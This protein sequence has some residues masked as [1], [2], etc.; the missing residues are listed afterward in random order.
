[1][2]TNQ[3]ESVTLEVLIELMETL[4][5]E[6]GC[7]WD[8]KQTKDSLK[9]Y[10]IEESY[11]VVEAVDERDPLKIKEELG[12]LLF[13]IVFYSQLLQKEDGIDIYD[14]IEA[15]HRKMV[16][17]HPHVF[18][19]VTVNGADEVVVNWEQIKQEEKKAERSSVLDGVPKELPS[20]LRAHR[21]QSKASS[22]GFEWENFHQILEKLDEEFSEL[23]QAYKHGDIEEIED[24]FGDLLFVL[25]S[26]ARF[27]H[28][29]PDNALR[30]AISKFTARFTHVERK[31]KEMDKEWNDMTTEEMERLWN[32]AKKYQ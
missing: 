18:G 8:R 23:R 15:V 22:V 2:D 6:R 1:M 26:I 11:E 29:N 30:K 9:P 19:E 24:E 21:L 28:V 3:K 7:P 17:R 4:L 13:Q 27:L 12:D 14:I 10:L 20:L 31:V 25:V 32:E 5:S 16:R